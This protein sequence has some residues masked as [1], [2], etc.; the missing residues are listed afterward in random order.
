MR[1]LVKTEADGTKVYSEMQQIEGVTTG[2]WI[3]V[4]R[5]GIVKDQRQPTFDE[6]AGHSPA[7]KRFGR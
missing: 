1:R 6:L 2:V 4:D 5:N 7:S 3:W